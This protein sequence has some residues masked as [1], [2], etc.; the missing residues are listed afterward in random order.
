M[1]RHRGFLASIA[2]ANRQLE[3]Q[4]RARE[5]ATAQ[6]SRE[7]QRSLKQAERDQKLALKE[8]EVAYRE[9]RE[10]E[11]EQKNSDL[12]ERI[13][14]LQNVLTARARSA[15]DGS[16]DARL[17]P[18]T[19]VTRSFARLRQVFTPA[20]FNPEATV[21]LAP[22]APEPHRF[23]P[24]LPPRPGFLARLFGGQ[25]KHDAA[26]QTTTDAAGA[27]LAEAQQ[28]FTSAL[29]KWE[30]AASTARQAH[31]AAERTR[32]DGVAKHN[33]EIDEWEQAFRQGDRDAVIQYSSLVLDSSE[34]DEDLPEEF[35]VAYS[36]E[37]TELIL[38]YVLPTFEV[39]PSVKEYSYVRAKDEIREKAR[40][41][42][43]TTTIY[44]TLIA[45]LTLRT[46]GELLRATPSEIVASVTFNGVLSTIDP[47]TG[48][49]VRP[50][51]ISVRTTREAFSSLHLDRV[52]PVACLASLG[53]SVSKKPEE[54]SAVRPVIEFDMADRR[55]VPSQDALAELDA[56]PNIMDLNPFEFENLV[57]NLFSKMGLDAKQTRSSRDGGVDCVAFDPR[58]VLGGKVVIQAKRYK[59]TVG[60]SAVRDLYG[61][62][63]NEG[64]NKGILVTTA[65]Y[66]PDAH[67]FA[68]DKPIELI[69]GGNLLYLLNQQGVQARIIMP[70]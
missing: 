36:P 63:M 4:Q 53:A 68:K 7:H 60:V 2:A 24:V 42:S 45:S 44:R 18:D 14:L 41:R 9:H 40:P 29:A 33:G 39:V 12:T 16:P 25:A 52:D 50:C 22:R 8:R 20:P 55:F 13:E 11:V 21:G 6:L 32:E 48:K 23:A 19:V 28:A 34:Y 54:L 43:D 27:R 35:R 3:R 26:V 67:D 38:E 58:P 62:M 15:S 64:A 17:S 61:T 1:G 65:G 56:R 49:D 69:D 46:I 66:G 10:D 57:T 5:R 47:A 31:L 37:S 51:V 59:N 70:V 30:H